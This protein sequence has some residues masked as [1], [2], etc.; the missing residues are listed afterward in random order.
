MKWNFNGEIVYAYTNQKELDESKTSIIFIH[1]AGFDHSVWTGF[2]RYFSRQNFNVIALDLP[3]HGYSEGP[4][5]TSISAISNWVSSVISDLGLSRVAIVGH[6]MGSL[7]AIEL[8]SK[9]IKQITSAIFIG[10]TAPMPVSETILEATSKAP[11]QA[12]NLLTEYGFSKRNLLGGNS[13]PGMWMVGECL[14]RYHREDVNVLNIDM[15]ACNSYSQGLEAAAKITCPCLMIQGD[16]DRLTPW[17]SSDNLRATIPGLRV[18]LVNGSGH[19]LM[20][21]A[22]NEVLTAMISFL[23]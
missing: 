3:G 16:S 18:R 22:P 7:V 5:R 20:Q 11:E 1:G 17:R 23:T 14:R 4:L 19:S 8:S 12:F 21:E 2:A 13:I 6:S 9:H 10:T 15:S